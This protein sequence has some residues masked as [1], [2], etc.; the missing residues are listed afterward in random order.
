M[1]TYRDIVGDGGSNVVAQVE[2]LEGAIA[3]ALSGVRHRLAV[4]SGKGGVGKSTLTAALGRALRRQGK[5]V[6][7]LDADFNGPCQARL[8]GLDAAPWIP[9]E[10]GLALPRSAEGIGIASLGSLL[11]EARPMEM[12]SVAV[13]GEHTW[14]ATREFALLA[15]LLAGV[16]WGELDVLLFDLPPG[17]ERTRQFAQFLGE[18]TAFVL[19]TLPSDLAQSVVARSISALSG[20][21]HRL[22]GYV[23]N[24]AGYYCVDCGEVKPLFPR[25]EAELAIPRLGS[26]PFDPALATLGSEDAGADDRETHRAIDAVA[27][28][29][30]EDL[31]SPP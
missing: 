16:D 30:L 27:R 9:D 6:A 12:A 4:G 19:V 29:I 23:E 11:P 13:G 15:Q 17:A 22:L 28:R 18:G 7:I 24:M 25:P 26:I 20:S 21:S 10:S 31:E 1:K 8:A 14:R 2:A 5:A 3:R